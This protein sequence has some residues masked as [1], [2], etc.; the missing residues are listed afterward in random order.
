M[1]PEFP[2]VDIRLELKYL[3]IDSLAL[4]LKLLGNQKI[5]SSY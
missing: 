3:F 5:S 2:K 1:L 4:L